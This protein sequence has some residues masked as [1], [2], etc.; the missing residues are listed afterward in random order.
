MKIG[1]NIKLEQINYYDGSSL[2]INYNEFIIMSIK[3]NL[4]K[5]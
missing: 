2:L 4:S 3:I 5:L 1:I